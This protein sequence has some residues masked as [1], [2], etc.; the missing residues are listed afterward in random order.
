MSADH[1][2]YGFE[3]RGYTFL[4]PFG[5]VGYVGN[6]KPSFPPEVTSR[7]TYRIWNPDTNNMIETR[8]VK[9]AQ[10]HGHHTYDPTANID[11][12]IP[13]KETNSATVR[14]GPS[15]TITYVKNRRG[16]TNIDD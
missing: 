1:L 7:H 13:P 16:A 2:W 10:W 15:E 6:S 5:Q 12:F 9:W 8:D 3:P 14:F 11:G 4:R